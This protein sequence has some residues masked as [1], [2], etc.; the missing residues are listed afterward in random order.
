MADLRRQGAENGP[1][2]TVTSQYCAPRTCS[3][4]PSWPA[5]GRPWP[6]SSSAPSARSPRPA[7]GAQFLLD[8]LTPYFDSGRVAAEAARR[9]SLSAR[10]MAYR[11]G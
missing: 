6:T 7:A 1:G 10:G 5:T 9:L 2:R 4:A 11:L 3:S 8:T